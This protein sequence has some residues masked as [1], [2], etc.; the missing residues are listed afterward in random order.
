ML[1]DFCFRCAADLRP[2]VGGDLLQG[3]AGRG[4]GGRRRRGRGRQ[5]RKLKLK[6]KRKRKFDCQKFELKSLKILPSTFFSFFADPSVRITL[7]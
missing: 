5:R 6:R 2:R 1:P 7:Q 3:E 4:R